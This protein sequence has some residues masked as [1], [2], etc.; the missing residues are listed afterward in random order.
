MAKKLM[1]SL[2][3]LIVSGFVTSPLDLESIS[4]GE[5]RLIVILLKLVFT[6]FLPFL[7]AISIYYRV[8]R[9]KY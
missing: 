3:V 1:V 2:V 4:S 5:A 6:S 7:I 8:L 9:L